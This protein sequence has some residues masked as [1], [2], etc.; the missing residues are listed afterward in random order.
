[1]PTSGPVTGGQILTVNGT[2]DKPPITAKLGASLCNVIDYNPPSGTAT[3]FRCYTP[4][5]S[6]GSVNVSATDDLGRTA[7][8]PNAYTYVGPPDMSSFSPLQVGVAGGATLSINGSNFRVGMTVTI[9]GQ[10]CAPVQLLAGGTQAQCT[11]P[12]NPE[13]SYSVTITNPDGQSDSIPQ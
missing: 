12:A 3:S 1:T 7:V 11:V 2:F 5:G 13:G 8:R 9:N 6:S 10:P 4:A